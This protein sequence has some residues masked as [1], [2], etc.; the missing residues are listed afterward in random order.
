MANDLLTI[1]PDRVRIIPHEVC[2]SKSAV[3]AHL[4]ALFAAAYRRPESADE[5]A[6]RINRLEAIGSSGIGGHIAMLHPFQRQDEDI[7]T[8]HP[9]GD[10]WYFLIPGGIDWDAIDAEPVHVVFASAF[11]RDARR[12]VCRKGVWAVL[13][14]WSKLP[15][16]ETVALATMSAKA[17]AGWITAALAEGLN[18]QR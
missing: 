10:F 13:R 14:V 17:A 9:V 15:A 3:I 4:T 2:S 7:E 1:S 8:A 12:D 18:E 11:R 6:A 16:K 5:W